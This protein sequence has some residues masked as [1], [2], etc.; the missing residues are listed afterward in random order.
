MAGRPREP[1]DFIEAK[2]KKHLTHREIENRKAQEVKAP[3]G[4]IC[5]PAYLNASTKKE[6]GTLAAQLQDIGIMANID[7]DALGRYLVLKEQWEKLTRAIYGMPIRKKGN[8]GK[9]HPNEE[10]ADMLKM[11]DRIFKDCSAAARDLGLTIS[12]RCR[13]VLPKAKEEKPE[14]KWDKFRSDAR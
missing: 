5:A 8:D 6:F 10:Y 14:S 2:G 11:Q 4:N 12:S 9:L 3:S 1:I 7:A 13:L